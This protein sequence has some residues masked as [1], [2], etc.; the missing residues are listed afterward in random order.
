[1]KASIVDTTEERQ[2]HHDAAA[3]ILRYDA[4]K[5]STISRTPIP[6]LPHDTTQ[7]KTQLQVAYFL[8]PSTHPR[9]AV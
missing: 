5:L 8:I 2:S 7:T 6:I 4:D 9:C 3:S 1:M